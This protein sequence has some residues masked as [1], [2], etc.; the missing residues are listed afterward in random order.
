MSLSINQ[1]RKILGKP[2]DGMTDEEIE[3][4][5]NVFVLLSDFAISSYLE[6]RKY[7]ADGGRY[8]NK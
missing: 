1:C 4:L 7:K 5:Q 3:H 2:G 6:K 8:E